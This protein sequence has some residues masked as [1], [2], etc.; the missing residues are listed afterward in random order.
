MHV[1][2]WGRA[3]SLERARAD[4]LEAEPDLEALCARSDVV[5]LHL[6]LSPETRGIVTARHLALMRPRALLVNTARA[7]LI[8][9]G[10][11]EAALS[12]GRPGRA[13]IDVF[14]D[15]P[16]TGDPAVRNPAVLATPHLGYVTWETYESYFREAFAQVNAFAA[17]APIGVVNPEALSIAA[18]SPAPRGEGQA[19]GGR[20]AARVASTSRPIWATSSSSEANTA[21]SRSRSQTSTTS[22]LP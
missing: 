11:L 6:K 3:A 13:A 17:G 9:R 14:D 7:G 4:G 1:L 16:A 18:G 10:A 21:S 12:A 2:A 8:E 5:S 15:E 19:S 22:R 20:T